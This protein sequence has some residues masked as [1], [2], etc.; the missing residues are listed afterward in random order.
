MISAPPTPS[1]VV[2]NIMFLSRIVEHQEW[3]YKMIV[4]TDLSLKQFAHTG[5]G[6]AQRKQ[7]TKSDSE[8]ACDNE[9]WSNDAE[10]SGINYILKYTKIEKGYFK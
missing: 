5:V 10:Y 6:I 4:S 7:S 1:E 3:N 2:D 8:G 9:V